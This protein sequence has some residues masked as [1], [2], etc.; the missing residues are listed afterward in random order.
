LKVEALSPVPDRKEAFKRNREKSIPAAPGC[1]V[2][3]NYAGD[4]L[5]IGLAIDLRRRFGQHLDNPQKTGLTPLGV[6]VFFHWR[7]NRDT[8]RLERTWMNIHQLA[9]GRLPI[10]NAV[11][12]PTST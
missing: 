2:L 11:Y 3:T 4:V 5:Y 12:S 7:E 8:N 6:A 10:L 1:Y 9:E